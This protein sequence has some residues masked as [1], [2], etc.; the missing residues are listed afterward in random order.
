MTE[1]ARRSWQEFED[2]IELL[3]RKLHPRA[4]VKRN[5]HLPGRV[6]GVARQIDVSIR[7]EL[8]PNELLIIVE[9][10][11]HGRKVGIEEMDAFVA[12]KNDVGAHL[13]IIISER[14]F[15]R[16]ARSVGD[17]A[18]IKAYT[19]RDTRREGWPGQIDVKI[20]VE[21]S[22]LHVHGYDIANEDGSPIKLPP[23]EK[24]R[25]FSL[26]EPH[27]E[28]TID[29]LIREIWQS[30][31]QKEGDFNLEL[32]ATTNPASGGATA[33][34][35]RFRLGFRAEIKRFLRDA[36]LELLGLVDS[37]DGTTHTDA[38]RL[39][40]QPGKGAQYFSEAEPW[41]KIKFAFA[42]VFTTCDVV[43]P[44]ESR[45]GP[46]VAVQRQFISMLPT[47]G[48]E[49]KVQAGEKP[50]SLNLGGLAVA[51]S[52]QKRTKSRPGKR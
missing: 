21:H 9:C 1:T 48:L 32:R 22:T 51:E 14:G 24:I 23:G 41:K 34:A 30:Q 3:H 47:L 16:G 35:Y 27:K 37:S 28:L 7:Y 42:A 43:L 52:H 39:I 33:I 15:T 19:L 25:L 29:D 44:D 12:K 18:G 46:M 11:R 13:G 20:F 2:V 36:S 40:T 17:A 4:V 8:G 45:R 10:K 26:K 6:S 49:I 31:G 38:F 50:I 5:D